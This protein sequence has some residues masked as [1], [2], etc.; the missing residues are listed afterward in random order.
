MESNFVSSDLSSD[1][2]DADKV[3]DR[4]VPH[5][6]G[7]TLMAYKL[8]MPVRSICIVMGESTGSVVTHIEYPRQ[9][10][11]ATLSEEEVLKCCQVL[12]A[13][14][15][16]ERFEKKKIDPLNL[17][18]STGDSSILSSFTDKPL[19]DFEDPA[20]KVICANRK[21]FRELCSKLRKKYPAVKEQITKAGTGEFVLLT[22]EDLDALLANLH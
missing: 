15:A 3:F 1:F 14:I 6:A 21:R 19:T 11:I 20:R 8:R 2:Y 7:H 10:E 17:D 16:G 13:G 5:E 22:N 9:E 12:G 18:P 4:A